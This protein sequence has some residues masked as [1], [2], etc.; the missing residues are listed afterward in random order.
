MQICPSAP[1]LILYLF[2]KNG[3]KGDLLQGGGG[4]QNEIS[5]NFVT[6]CK[7]RTSC[8]FSFT[9]NQMYELMSLF[10]VA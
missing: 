5:L 6:N 2:V 1:L 7:V 9:P 10:Y 8:K 4:D 3:G